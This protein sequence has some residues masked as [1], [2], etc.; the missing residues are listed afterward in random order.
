MSLLVISHLRKSF[1]GAVALK[2]ASLEL[3]AGET[4]G[5]MGE[6]GAGKSTLIRI[7]A[8]AVAPDG[9]EIRLD[10]SRATLRAPG[11]AHRLGLRF[12]HQ[13]LNIVPALSVAEN[14]FLGRDYP[15][16]LGLINWRLLEARAHAALATL[17]VE[18][19]A[20][21]TIMA[22]LSV[23]DRMLVK[24]AA[25]FLEEE[26]DAPARIFIM[27]EP[28]AALTGVESERLFRIIAT[29]RSR[30]GGILYVSHR[31]DEVLAI[32]DRITVLR[33]GEVRATLTTKDASKHQLIELMTGRRE[34]ELASGSIGPAVA[35]GPVVLTVQGLADDRLRD[36]SFELHKGEIL[37]VTGLADAGSEQVT[38]SIVSSD[39]RIKIALEG[40]PIRIRWPADAWAS[41]I[42]SAPRERRAEGLLLGDDIASN[43]ALPHLN[44]LNRLR[45]FINRRREIARAIAM[46]Q[47]VSLKATGP[48][49]KVRQLSG[50]NQQKV[51][52]A[53]AVAG[54]PRVLLLDEPT[55]GVDV[56]AKFDIYTLL[57]ELAASGT[58]I[59][60]VSS[61][62]QEILHIC[63]RV[64]VMREGRILAITSTSGLS[65]QQLLS[66][67]YGEAA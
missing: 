2:D 46:G 5:L 41:G 31:L 7:L 25:A 27:D 58:A 48:L 42:A 60:V 43:V 36:V 1:G 3:R 40:K 65:P 53:R 34:T 63:S 33:D 10:D 15:R 28:T 49:Q 13:E 19:I 44:W 24:I 23:G 12:I 29:L 4:L 17:G 47:R 8:G 45:F 51:M 38:R 59:L 52:F 16:R 6:N 57:R 61:D 26:E 50:G 9:G 35:A 62:Q 21:K 55:R 37:G 39:H 14:I 54:S 67:C 18:H 30:G 20:P 32:T 22:K 11:E 56:G 66:L 64:V